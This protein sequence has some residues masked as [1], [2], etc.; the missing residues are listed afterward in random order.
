[1][2]AHSYFMLGAANTD[3]EIIAALECQW[4][5]RAYIATKSLL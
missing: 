1:M 2:M 5:L 3:M 4:R